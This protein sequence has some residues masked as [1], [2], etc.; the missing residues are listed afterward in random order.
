MQ[1]S[2]YTEEYKAFLIR[3]KQARKEKGLTQLD[4]AELLGKPQSYIAKC[5]N[6]ERR[7]DVIELVEFAKIYGKPINYFL[8]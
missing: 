6:G 5:E 1:K 7:V 4:V 8:E 3:I 2:I